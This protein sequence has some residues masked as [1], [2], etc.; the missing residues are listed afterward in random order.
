M[1]IF[2]ISLSDAHNR[3]NS[4]RNRLSALGLDFEFFDAVDGRQGIPECYTHMVD[5]KTAR[6]NVGRDMHDVEICCA[7]SH[8]LVYQKIVDEN[9]T[10]CVILEDDAIIDDAFDPI[11]RRKIL[12]KSPHSFIIFNHFRV[13]KSIFDTGEKLYKKYR[14]YTSVGEAYCTGGYY[15]NI[16]MANMLR[17]QNTP[18]VHMADWPLDVN[19][20]AVF[21]SPKLIQQPPLTMH[22]SAIESMRKNTISNNNKKQYR[23]TLRAVGKIILT[24]YYIFGW[25]M[26]KVFHIKTMG[27]NT[28]QSLKYFYT[29]YISKNFHG[30]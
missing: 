12:Q 3:R 7:L 6:K 11:I 25:I 17:I 15:I 18:I 20:Y 30:H 24:P 5:T 9:I 19:T 4:I 27:K 1:K 16:H 21:T 13:R 23:Q 2:V 14:L 29:V 28:E 22:D 10:D 8:V 26:Y